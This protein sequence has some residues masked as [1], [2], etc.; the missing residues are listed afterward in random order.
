MRVAFDQRGVTFMELVV[1]IAI[2]LIMLAFVVTN[3]TSSNNGGSVISAAHVLAGDIRNVQNKSQAGVLLDGMPNVEGYGIL[4]DQSNLA[5]ATFYQ[6]FGDN[7]NHEY[8]IGD[9]IVPGGE[10]DFLTERG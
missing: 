3:F 4:L 2:F 9:V 6:L 8:G 7:G 1:S 10:K 5:S